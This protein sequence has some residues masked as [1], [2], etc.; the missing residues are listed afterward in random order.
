MFIMRKLDS[1][2][3]GLGEDYEAVL[4]EIGLGL[5]RNADLYAANQENTDPSFCFH[6]QFQSLS[7]N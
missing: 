4:E 6:F 3:V 5:R 2:D 7:L 1:E